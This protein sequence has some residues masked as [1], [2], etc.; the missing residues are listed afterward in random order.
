MILNGFLLLLE[1]F[2]DT[3]HCQRNG[4]NTVRVDNILKVCDFGLSKYEFESEYDETPNFSA[5]EV[6]ISQ[7]QHYQPQADIWSIGAILYYMAY[8]KQP[9][10]NPEN[11]AWEPPY[12]HQP[13]QDPLVRDLLMKALQYYPEDP[14]GDAGQLN[15]TTR[16]QC[17]TLCKSIRSK[18]RQQKPLVIVFYFDKGDVVISPCKRR[19]PRS[20]IEENNLDESNLVDIS[21]E[22]YRLNVNSPDHNNASPVHNDA[23]PDHN[24]D[25]S[26]HNDASPDHNDDSSVHNDAS[27]DRYDASVDINMSLE[28]NQII[29]T[30]QNERKKL[31]TTSIAKSIK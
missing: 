19:M 26:V 20:K 6:L 14:D 15:K 24:D 1:V 10:W 22:I 31:W 25:S 9:N 21:N 30:L 28:D 8:G 5:P 4:Q 18:N 13:V 2:Y 3:L 17:K 29:I 23:S 11:R 16:R 7:E 12:G 27:P